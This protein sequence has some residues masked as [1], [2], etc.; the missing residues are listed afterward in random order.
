MP[1]IPGVT[2]TI[3]N[4]YGKGSG[5]FTYVS[6]FAAW[7]R[8]TALNVTLGDPDVNSPPILR[9][10]SNSLGSDPGGSPVGGVMA[11]VPQILGKYYF[12]FTCPEISGG[13]GGVGVGL[14][15]ASYEGMS[16]L[17][18]AAV[19]GIMFIYG[20]LNFWV[21]G[22]KSIYGFNSGINDGTTGHP[23]TV[24]VAID[25]DNLLVWFKIV[26][27]PSA[28]FI[29]DWNGF[30][31]S[32]ISNPVPAGGNP[33]LKINGLPLQSGLIV[34]NVPMAIFGTAAQ[35]NSTI[36]NANF[37]QHL[38]ENLDF[39]FIGDLAGYTYWPAVL[40]GV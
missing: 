39:G 21:N 30:D 34:G 29:T 26:A 4:P 32:D 14:S 31:L 18:T 28:Q 37:G 33:A 22:V 8:T 9:Q 38:F 16:F 13:N 11:E 10:A 12:E 17:V 5:R 25:L 3:H 7:D 15:T 35:P 6:P 24:G 23:D 40:V 19:G 27:G 1:I 36:V 20:S 2:I